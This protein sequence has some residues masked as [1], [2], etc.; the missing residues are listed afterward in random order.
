MRF[1]SWKYSQKPTM[2]WKTHW[3]PPQTRIVSCG[4]F[5]SSRIS[6]NGPFSLLQNLSSLWHRNSGSFSVDSIESSKKTKGFSERKIK[7]K[8]FC[9]FRSDSFTHKKTTHIV[10][11]VVPMPE[12]YFIA[13]WSNRKI[14]AKEGTISIW[15]FERNFK[16][17]YRLLGVLDCSTSGWAGYSYNLS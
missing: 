2:S 7:Q 11:Q 14:G 13:S 4:A 15:A 10:A 17:R 16:S 5:I 9:R 3:G 12:R 1:L 6:K 8:L